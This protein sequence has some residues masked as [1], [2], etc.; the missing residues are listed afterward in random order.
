V[1]SLTSAA[2]KKKNIGFTLLPEFVEH[3]DEIFTNL[4]H[5]WELIAVSH[6]QKTDQ[7]QQ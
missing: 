1:I 4:L 3:A 6:K 2:T 5:C 7:Q